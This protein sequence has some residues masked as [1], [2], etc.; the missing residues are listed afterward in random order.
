[1]EAWYPAFHSDGICHAL[2]ILESIDR[3]RV[4]VG[5]SYAITSTDTRKAIILHLHTRSP[6]R[7]C[8]KDNFLS[9][10]SYHNQGHAVTPGGSSKS[11]N[12]KEPTLRSSAIDRRRD[13]EATRKS[14]VLVT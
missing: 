2:D 3:R 6:V 13:L 1:M 11:L 8:N 4:S 5:E 7:T 10:T 12:P 14:S 9:L